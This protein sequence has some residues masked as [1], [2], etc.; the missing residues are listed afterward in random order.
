M[1]EK[2]IFEKYCINK[3]LG[4]LTNE[5]KNE[6]KKSL[7]YQSY[8]LGLA[9]KHF[10]NE[11]SQ[12]F[13]KV[14]ADIFPILKK[15]SN[16]LNEIEVCGNCINYNKKNKIFIVHDENGIMRQASNC[17]FM[18]SKDPVF[19]TGKA[20]PLFNPKKNKESNDE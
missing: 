1:N 10:P 11:L 20:C 15:I 9:C 13:K 4:E 19:W 2:Q 18:S 7:E 16:M 8:V 12:A 3:G 6:I 14:S 5:E 17:F